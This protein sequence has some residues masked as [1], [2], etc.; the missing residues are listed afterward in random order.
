MPIDADSETWGSGSLVDR[1]STN[2]AHRFLMENPDTAYSVEE[3]TEWVLEEHP[4]L[5]PQTLRDSD[6]NKE[7][8]ALVASVLD[9]LDR[10][11][12]VTCKAVV[13]EE[14]QTELYYKDADKDAHYPNVKLEHEVPERFSDVE[15]DV[16]D[17]EERL[18]NL[19][20]QVRTEVDGVW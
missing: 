11:R 2:I 7:V 18:S 1:L 20:Y 13:T 16:S 9:R 6:N 4:E 3:I 12:F 15:D 8:M 10:R 14:G 19:E 17:L 5:V